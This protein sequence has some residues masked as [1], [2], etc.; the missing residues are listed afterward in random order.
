MNAWMAFKRYSTGQGDLAMD[1]G[2]H[3]VPVAGT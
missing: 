3:G 1:R 2:S